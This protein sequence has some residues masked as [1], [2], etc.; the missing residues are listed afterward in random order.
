MY[1]YLLTGS[2]ASKT[3]TL[4][5][6][7]WMVTNH[8]GSGGLLESV[9]ALKNRELPRMKALAKGN[10]VTSHSYPFTRGTGNYLTA[11]VDA[12]ILEP[13]NDW[14]TRAEALIKKTIHPEDNITNRDL[15]NVETGWSY[16]ILLSAIARYLQ[17]KRARNQ[18]DEP[19]QFAAASLLAYTNWMQQN[20]RPFLADTSQLEFANHTWVAQ[21][22]RKAMLIFQT[23]ELV[24]Q[25]KANSLISTA[26]EWL[27]QVCDSLKGSDERHFS[28]ILVILMQNYGPHLAAI[29]ASYSSSRKDPELIK[30]ESLKLTWSRL[31]GRITRRLLHSV[32]RL[33]IAKEKAWLDTLRNK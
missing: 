8:E 13:E 9:L 30:S 16:L 29:P 32:R 20:E 31:I 23:A 28:R 22:I 27:K 10:L 21:D 1:H 4:E 3:A 5:L 25:P 19:Y 7:Q 24:S 18:L 6:A 14:L 33:D 17:E 2:A 26:Q 12:S 15:L 11:L